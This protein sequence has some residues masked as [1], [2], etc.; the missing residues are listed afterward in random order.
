MVIAEIILI[1]AYPKAINNRIDKFKRRYRHNK[2][3]T[4]VS[5]S[6]GVGSLYLTKYVER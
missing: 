2:K 1:G 6:L 5:Q 4:G 3:N